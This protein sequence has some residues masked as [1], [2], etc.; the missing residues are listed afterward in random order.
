MTSTA[1]YYDRESDALVKVELPEPGSVWERVPNIKSLI[2]D[3][4]FVRDV[5]KKVEVL[6]NDV[7]PDGLTLVKDLKDGSKDAF[8]PLWFKQYYK[9]TKHA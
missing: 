6:P 5:P 8:H 1:T 7:N 3:G 4:M 2:P 9:E